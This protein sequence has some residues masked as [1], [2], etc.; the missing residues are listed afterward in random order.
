M[1]LLWKGK[2]PVT[3]GISSLLTHIPGLCI[4]LHYCF[5]L[6][7]FQTQAGDDRGEETGKRKRERGGGAYEGQEEATQQ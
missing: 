5:A 2:S 6:E 4:L 7:T 3:V 1:T